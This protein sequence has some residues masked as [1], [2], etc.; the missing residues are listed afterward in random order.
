MS[1]GSVYLSTDNIIEIYRND[2][3]I[4]NTV[5]LRKLKTKNW[6]KNYTWKI[7][8]QFVSRQPDV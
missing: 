7:K 3:S 6:V 1:E 4:E 2:I 5:M 8:L